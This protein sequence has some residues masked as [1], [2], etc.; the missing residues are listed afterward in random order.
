MT[1]LENLAQLQL[2]EKALAQRAESASGA[3]TL[4]AA[5]QRA[6]RF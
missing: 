4:A 2:T 1:A 6:C 5:A 3:G